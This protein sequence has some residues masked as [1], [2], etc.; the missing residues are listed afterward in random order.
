MT[1]RKPRDTTKP[2]PLGAVADRVATLILTVPDKTNIER[3]VREMI[4]KQHAAHRA[5][6]QV[7]IAKLEAR[8]APADRERWSA[9]MLARMA[10]SGL[11]GFELGGANDTAPDAA[12]ELE[13]PAQ[14]TDDVMASDT[15]PVSDAAEVPER[16]LV[17]LSDARLSIGKGR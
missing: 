3:Q 5:A 2:L 16:L 17:P 14:L 11:C 7:S 13:S 1:D 8:I 4:E 12:F 10:P 9:F 15:P 6:V